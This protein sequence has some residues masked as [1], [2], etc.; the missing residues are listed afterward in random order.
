M[1]VTV[2]SLSKKYQKHTAVHRIS[3]SI[4]K[5]RCI[6]LLGPNGAGKTTTLQMLAGLL[7]PTGGTIEF[8]GNQQKDNRARIGG[9]T[10][11]KPSFEIMV[12]RMTI[13]GGAFGF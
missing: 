2:K 12:V 10:P 4:G 1:L 3:F 6:A 5:G 8:A 13:T 9:V 11:L 7:K